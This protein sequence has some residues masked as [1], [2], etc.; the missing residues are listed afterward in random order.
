MYF[1]SAEEQRWVQRGLLPEARRQPV[2]E[3]LRGWSWH[4]PPLKPVYDRPLGVYEVAGKYCPTGRDL[5]L[6]R[7]QEV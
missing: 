7:V 3:E 6:R 1:A 2:A 5:F 4:Q